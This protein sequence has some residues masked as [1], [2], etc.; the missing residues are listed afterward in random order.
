LERR[1][2][3]YF[4]LQNEIQARSAIAAHVTMMSRFVHQG[5]D[6]ARSRIAGRHHKNA[7]MM[8]RY[9]DESMPADS[10]PPRIEARHETSKAAGRRRRY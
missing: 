1:K 5:D 2:L 7:L 10:V 9:L 8:K 4:A 3:T 6:N